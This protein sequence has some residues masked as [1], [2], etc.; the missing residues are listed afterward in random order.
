MT[1]TA[2]DHDPVMCDEIVAAFATVPAGVIVDAT[3]GGGGHSEALL[4]SRPDVDVIGLD[5]DP[6]AIEAASQ[7]LARFGDRFGCDRVS[8]DMLGDVLDRRGI[9]TVSAVLF[10]LGVS[11]HQLDTAARGFSYRAAGPIDMRM[12]PDSARSAADLIDH[13]RCRRTHRD[14]AA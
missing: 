1:A 8:F 3:L 9:R 13:A 4:Q 6:A 10:D 2:F 5:R 11:S 7:R 12:D 14:S